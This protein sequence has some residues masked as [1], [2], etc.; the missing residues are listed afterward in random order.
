MFDSLFLLGVG[1]RTVYHGPATDCRS[2]FENIGFQ[3][4]EGESQADWFLDISSGDVV[5]GDI[6]AVGTND[7]SEVAKQNKELAFGQSFEVALR[8]EEEHPDLVLSQLGG[9]DR[10]NFVIKEVGKVRYA[11]INSPG[12]D[13]QVGDKVVGINGDGIDQLTLEDVGVLLSK[14]SISTTENSIVFIQILRQPEGEQLVQVSEDSCED[15]LLLNPDKPANEEG[16]LVKAQMAREM[17][18]R[19][20]NMN[21]EILSPS[22]KKIYYDPPNPFSLPNPPKPV[23]GWRQLLVQLH[24]NCLLSWRNGNSRLIDFGILIIAVFAMVRD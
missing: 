9:F 24:R 10:G 16:A 4:R 1:G 21:F 18:Y 22:L 2:Y 5:S 3:M 23:P 20:W 11:K 17:L 13:I 14:D 7:G 19:Q 8:V 12:H 6:K 15:S